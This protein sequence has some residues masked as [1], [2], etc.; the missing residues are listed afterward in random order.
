MLTYSQKLLRGLHLSDSR[1]LTVLPLLTLKSF[2]TGDV[3]L[4]KDCSVN[5]WSCVVSG[6]VA[7]S[8]QLESGKRLPVHIFGQDEWFGE[9][10][11]LTNQSCHFDY[12]SLTPV[13]LI[14]MPR[15]CFDKALLDDQAFAQFLLSLV[16]YRAQQHG[17]MLT[18]M[19]LGSSPLQVA[20]GLAQF[21]E[22]STQKMFSSSVAL[23]PNT[24]DIPISQHHLADYCGVSRTLFSEYIQH[25]SLAGWLKL[26]YGGIELK[27]VQTWRIF[28]QRQRKRKIVNSKPTIQDLLKDMSAANAE[29]GPYRFPNLLSTRVSKLERS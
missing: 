13:E 1:I 17:D 22:T 2:E 14:A 21:V 11:L 3:I 7:A 9:Q 25:L 5:S 23:F 6:F 24:V 18:L 12:T 16:A 8:V 27:S 4:E 15:S 20:M 28:A 29:I 26:R 10:S 19:R